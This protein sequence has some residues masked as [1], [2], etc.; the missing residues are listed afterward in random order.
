MPKSTKEKL[1]ALK[2]GPL[3]ALADGA[4]ARFSIG[5]GDLTSFVD[6]L[7]EDKCICIKDIIVGDPRVTG[8]AVE[9]PG[10]GFMDAWLEAMNMGM[11]EKL[12]I[13]MPSESIANSLDEL[14][15]LALDLH[16]APVVKDL[17]VHD[18][19]TCPLEE[20][21]VLK[22]VELEVWLLIAYGPYKYYVRVVFPV[23]YDFRTTVIVLLLS[24]DAWEEVRDWW[25]RLK[26][27]EI[28]LPE[29][30]S[31]LPPFLFALH[32]EGGGSRGGSR[33]GASSV[34]GGT[35][36][37]QPL[38][39]RALLASEPHSRAVRMPARARSSA[40][41]ETHPVVLAWQ[42]LVT[43]WAARMGGVLRRAQG[44]SSVRDHGPVQSAREASVVQR[45]VDSD[46]RS[47][48]MDRTLP[49]RGV[50]SPHGS[51]SPEVRKSE[52]GCAGGCA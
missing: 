28:P 38:H 48:S 8:G 52:G 22:T 29:W 18:L 35:P 26:S 11:A 25:R 5:L 13:S 21:C 46:H 31:W 36:L 51:T 12:G 39:P 6:S 44:G 27:G 7:I 20:E 3:L 23:T 10:I 2:Q 33:S 4:T 37:G 42:F 32:L 49:T 41:R 43:A 24:D 19:M 34:I 14:F 30:P 40:L 1:E 15:Q 16:V 9:G 47:V 50:V 45:E 17:E